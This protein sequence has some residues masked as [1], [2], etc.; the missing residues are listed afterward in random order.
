VFVDDPAV[1]DEL[2]PAV[3]EAL[4][5]FSSDPHAA[6]KETSPTPAINLSARR[7][8]MRVDRSNQR[9]RS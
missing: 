8:S 5:A 6:A 1:V 2:D 4:G 9:P 3:V 7:R